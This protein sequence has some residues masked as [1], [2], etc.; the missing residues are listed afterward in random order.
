M[1]FTNPNQ[2][3]KM[4][5]LEGYTDPKDIWDTETDND[6]A[7]KPFFNVTE[8]LSERNLEH[9]LRLC[10]EKIRTFCNELSDDFQRIFTSL[11]EEY[12][13]EHQMPQKVFDYIREKELLSPSFT[14]A[15]GEP[16]QMLLE[17]YNLPRE[18]KK[19]QILL[20]FQLPKPLAQFWWKGGD[21]SWGEE[22]QRVGGMVIEW[23]H[24]YR[25][26]MP[27]VWQ[28]QGRHENE[29]GLDFER[30]NGLGQHDPKEYYYVW[31]VSVWKN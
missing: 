13:K 29:N 17:K 16:A 14:T 5:R 28:A 25:E 26:L 22:G 30:V 31:K 9:D 1:K 27:L 18:I 7:S 12:Q 6:S 10:L 4:R 11:L 2:F 21:D 19:E 20:V 24:F 3:E 15:V 23:G 8:L